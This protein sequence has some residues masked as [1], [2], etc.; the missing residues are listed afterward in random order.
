MAAPS[1]AVAHQRARIARLTQSYPPDHPKLAEAK[2]DF[3][4]ASLE[5]AV[6]KALQKAPR[7][8]DSQLQ[9]IASL[10]LAGATTS[11]PQVDRKTVVAERVAELDCGGDH[12][13]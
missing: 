12:A 2:R 3:N 11:T 8:T 5:A 6:L 7:P 4:A 13:A 10:L 9:R 1:P